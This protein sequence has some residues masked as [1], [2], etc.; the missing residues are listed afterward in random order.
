VSTLRTPVRVRWWIFLYTFLFAM[1]IYVQHNSMS[2]AAVRIMPELHLSQMQV[3]WLMETFAVVYM[4]LQLPGG[5]LGERI[6]ARATYVVVGVVTFIA[7]ITTPLAPLLLS[8]TALFVALVL[9]QALM[10]A[11]HAPVFPVVA[12]VYES[13]FPVTRWSF[14]NGVNSSG[15]NLGTALTAPLIVALMAAFGW[16]RALLWI[17]LPTA[18]LTTAWAWYVRNTPREHPKV[19]PAELAELGELAR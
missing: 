13:W 18:L 17:G 3:G 5:V 11:A 7:T 10:A 19:T 12:G 1:L 9:A 15:L 16:Q 8:G 4:V 6:G 14:V 2:I